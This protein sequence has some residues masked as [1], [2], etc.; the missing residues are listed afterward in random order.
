MT[1]RAGTCRRNGGVLTRLLPVSIC[2]AACV[3]RAYADDA[4]SVT[5]WAD[6]AI[7]VYADVGE[8]RDALVVDAEPHELIVKLV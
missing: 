6:D 1:K 5:S 7:A 8:F 4:G 3:A 2:V